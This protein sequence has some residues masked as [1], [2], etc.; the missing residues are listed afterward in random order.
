VKIHRAAVAVSVAAISSVVMTAAP[1]NA[2]PYD[3]KDPYT[4][5]CANTKVN[6][7]KKAL[8]KNEVGDS[9]GTIRL[10]YSRRCGTNWGEVSV[11]KS[12]SGTITVFASR[13]SRSF[14]Y[15]AGN[16]GHHWGNMVHAPS[17]VCAKAMGSVTAGI[18]RANKGSG[19]TPKACG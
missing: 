13:T 7:G 6:T 17:G 14:S 8:L 12:G 10:F 1:A 11:S 9:L 15:R 4:T 5:G 3:G 19:T 16:G 18:G 2:Q